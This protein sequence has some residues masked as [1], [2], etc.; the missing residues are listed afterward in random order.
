M[1]YIFD[2]CR[3]RL[4]VRGVYCVMRRYDD[5]VYLKRRRTDFLTMYD[6]LPPFLV[7]TTNPFTTADWREVVGTR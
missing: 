7:S 5:V 1:L 4:L 6:C 3:N 2:I